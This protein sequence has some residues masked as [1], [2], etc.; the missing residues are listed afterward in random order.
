MAAVKDAIDIARRPDEVFA[1]LDD[2]SRHGE[3][4]TSVASVHVDG[5]PTAVGT[6]ATETRRLA[7]L[8]YRVTYVITSRTP[9]RGFEFE[10]VGSPLQPV[11]R[12][13]IEPLDEGSRSRVTIEMDFRGHGVG[14]LLVPLARRWARMHVPHSQQRLKERL[15]SGA[16]LE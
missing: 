10:G 2:L 11:G 5:E 14:K 8:K 16:D 12:R 1:Y 9:P 3:W 13:T 4:E 6:K 7:G 15:E